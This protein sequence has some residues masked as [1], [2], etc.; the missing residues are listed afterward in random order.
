MLASLPNGILILALTLAITPVWAQTVSSTDSPDALFQ[1]YQ[2]HLTQ[3]PGSSGTLIQNN[4]WQIDQKTLVQKMAKLEFSLFL[5]QNQKPSLLDKMID[6]LDRSEFNETLNEVA[7][8]ESVN[9]LKQS[10]SADVA[11]FIQEFATY[12]RNRAF[13]FNIVQSNF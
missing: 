9:Y 7:L 13:A 12:R 8:D 3:F 6:P 10:Q 5:E 1:A 4:Q 2:Q 11:A